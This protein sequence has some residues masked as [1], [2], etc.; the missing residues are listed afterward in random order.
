MSVV[1]STRRPTSFDCTWAKELRAF[2]GVE[3]AYAESVQIRHYVI[4]F[5]SGTEHSKLRQLSLQAD[6]MGFM[7]GSFSE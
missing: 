1:I 2:N 5:A 6:F 4:D 7:E 3:H